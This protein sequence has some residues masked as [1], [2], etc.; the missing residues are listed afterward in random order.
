M[1]EAIEFSIGCF[2]DNKPAMGVV[3]KDLTRDQ[4]EQFVR[5][6]SDLIKHRGKQK[7]AQA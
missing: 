1:A 2:L 7:E 5:G 4:A 6:Y 3:R